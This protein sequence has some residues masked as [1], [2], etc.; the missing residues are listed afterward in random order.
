MILALGSH[1]ISSIGFEEEFT[2]KKGE[3]KANWVYCSLSHERFLRE[4]E[5]EKKLGFEENSFLKILER[6]KIL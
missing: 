5:Q 1:L 3:A 2:H 6:R 4:Q